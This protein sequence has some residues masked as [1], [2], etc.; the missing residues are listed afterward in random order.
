MDIKVKKKDGRIEAFDQN[1]IKNGLV[2]SGALPDQVIKVTADV[3]AWAST[4]AV[5]GV[6]GTMEIRSKVIELLRAVNPQAAADFEAYRKPAA[7]P[8]AEPVA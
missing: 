5:E 6:I 3:E 7:E 8:T 1:K 2:K 4:A